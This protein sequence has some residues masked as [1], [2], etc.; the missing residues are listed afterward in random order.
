MNLTPIRLG[1]LSSS[2]TQTFDHTTCALTV[3]EWSE[4]GMLIVNAT[5]SFRPNGFEQEI[6]APIMLRFTVS[7]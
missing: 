6:N 5:V 2:L 7:P 4:L 1:L 3:N